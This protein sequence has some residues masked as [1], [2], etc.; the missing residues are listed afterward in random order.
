MQNLFDHLITLL[1]T[2]ARLVSESGDLFKNKTQELSYKLDPE[3]LALLIRDQKMKAQFFKSV[4]D[5]VVFDQQKFVNFINNK[6][7]LPDSYTSFKNKIGLATDRQHYLSESGEVVLNRPYKDA[8]LAGWQSS[9][10]AKRDEIF[11]NQTL[12]PDEIDRLLDPKAFTNFKK[13][14][15]DGEQ[16]FEWF[17]RN[18][19]WTITDNLLI[20][21]NNLLALHSLKKEFAGKVKLIYIDPPYNTGWDSNTFTYNNRFNHSTW[22]TFMKNRL[23]VAKIFLKNEWFIAIAIDHYELFYLWVLCDE[24]FWRENRLWIVSVIHKPGWRNQEKFFASSNEFMLV[25]AK[26]KEFANFNKVALDDEVKKRF[27]YVDEDWKYDLIN[28]VRDH[29]DNLREK[30]PNQ[31]YPIYVNEKTLEL[32]LEKSDSLVELWP[33]SNSW[34]E[35]T[36][37][38][39][40]DTF[41]E[42]YDRWEI[43]AKNENWKIQIFRKFREQQI[44]K[45]HWDSKK[46]NSTHY[47]TRLL[48]K[49][50]WRKWVSFPKS[51][52]LIQDIIKIMT[53]E[54][55]IIMDFHAGSWTT[56]HA[57]LNLNKADWWD[58]K[59]I[60][61]E[62]L[63]EHIDVCIERNQKI[64]LNNEQWEF[65]YMEIA[66]N[67]QSLIE[68]IQS[69]DDAHEL[70]ALYD[71]LQ[72]S[73]FV[74]YKVDVSSLDKYSDDFKDLELDQMKQLLIEL[75]DQNALY[76]NHSEMNDSHYNLSDE[77]K[78]WTDD[79]YQQ[80][81]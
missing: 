22:L 18:D 76:I 1:K 44:I 63:Q 50:I 47:W 49:I 75:I 65:I 56:W 12:A 37:K 21:G 46:Y 68:Q 24:I 73:S 66:E 78:R 23:E 15:P 43:V 71:D 35:M 51:L 26:N 40:P 32:S 55:D 3:L 2:D 9:E 42:E 81:Q 7:F 20:K 69:I 33:I 70:I 77:D 25:Y 67:N 53:K 28:F 41:L 38:T 62:Q 80:I 54:N 60:L 6:D 39:S 34:R 30:K 61:I 5:I 74:N 36:W 45:T 8:I 10:D 19:E 31:W 48:E 17:Q 72:Q 27:I 79:F 64:C 11:Y 4:D 29:I 59:F 16:S 57:I 13:Y 14:T 52:Y 58:R